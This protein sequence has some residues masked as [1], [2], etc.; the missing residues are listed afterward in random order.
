VAG[1][2]VA[3]VPRFGGRLVAG[4]PAGIVISLLTIP[5]H[6]DIALRDFG[7]LLGAVA[8]ARLAQRYRGKR[9]SH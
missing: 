5:W 9:P 4:W 6:Y 3:L 8:P 1:I 7:L 2:V